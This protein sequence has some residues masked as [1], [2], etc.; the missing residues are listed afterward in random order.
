MKWLNRLSILLFGLLSIGV[1]RDFNSKYQLLIFD[2]E[3][4]DTDIDIDTDQNGFDLSKAMDLR[5]T[6]THECICG[7]NIWNIKAMFDNFEIVTYFLDM[8]CDNCGSYAT[9]P[10][11]LDSEGMEK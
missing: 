4:L 5:G 11:P 3:D 2:K 8:V 10:T 9:A 6:P 1:V 7:S